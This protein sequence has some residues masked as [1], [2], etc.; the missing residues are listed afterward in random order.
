MAERKIKPFCLFYHKTAF[1]RLLGMRTIWSCYF[2]GHCWEAYVLYFC[3]LILCEL[4]WLKTKLNMNAKSNPRNTLEK[5]IYIGQCCAFGKLRPQKF[6]TTPQT[7]PGVFL[8][9]KILFSPWQFWTA[10]V[11]WHL[12]ELCISFSSAKY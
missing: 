4:M 1:L 11:L 3:F 10:H 2:E 7:I 5:F 9:F 12:P 8:E 6:T